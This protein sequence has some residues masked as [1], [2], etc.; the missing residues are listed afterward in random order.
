[1]DKSC[2]LNFSY[3]KKFAAGGRSCSP[4]CKTDISNRTLENEIKTMESRRRNQPR[5]EANSRLTH[6]PAH[7]DKNNISKTANIFSIFAKKNTVGQLI[8]Q[9]PSKDFLYKRAM[10]RDNLNAL[11]NRRLQVNSNKVTKKN[12]VGSLKENL[13]VINSLNQQPKSSSSTNRPLK[14]SAAL[15]EDL[16]NEMV[17]RSLDMYKKEVVRMSE[18]ATVTKLCIFHNE[19][20]AEFFIEKSFGKASNKAGLCPSCAV[21]L[22]S[23]S[24]PISEITITLKPKDR[25]TQINDIKAEISECEAFFTSKNAILKSN[26]F[27]LQ[28]NFDIQKAKIDKFFMFIFQV[29]EKKRFLWEEN[30][31]QC[32]LNEKNRI[33]SERQVINERMVILEKIKIDVFENFPK[34]NDQLKDCDFEAIVA[35]LESKLDEIKNSSKH[36]SHTP[37][38]FLEKLDIKKTVDTVDKLLEEEL[39]SSYQGKYV[40]ENLNHQNVWNEQQWTIESD[41]EQDNPHGAYEEMDHFQNVHESLHAIDANIPSIENMMQIVDEHNVMEQSTKMRQKM[42][43]TDPSSY[44]TNRHF[45]VNAHGGPRHVVPNF[46]I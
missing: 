24:F 30:L 28:R 45:D 37:F 3:L 35:N 17:T 7:T 20:I 38:E 29:V 42:I 8:Q 2:F 26:K 6:R 1:M 27:S 19:R 41:G 9:S 12:L 18:T 31:R 14:H 21:K 16:D 46:E 33:E 44:E 25:T 10:G 43:Y 23:K 32:F 5:S 15:S 11:T 40:L 4:S 36:I 39:A 34:I 22:A 13:K